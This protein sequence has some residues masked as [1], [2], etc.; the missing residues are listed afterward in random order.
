MTRVR[1]FTALFLTI[2]VVLLILFFPTP[3][4]ALFVLLV[5]VLAAREWATL[6]NRTDRK[7]VV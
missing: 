6:L 4:F 2:P 3:F 7:S 5:L 1:F